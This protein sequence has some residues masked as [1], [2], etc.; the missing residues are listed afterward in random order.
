MAL[1]IDAS[2]PAV[3]TSATITVTTA[4]FT[5][6]AGAKLLIGWSGNSDSLN[7]PG[8]PTITDNLG[9]H[10]TYTLADFASRLDSPFVAGMA[11][12][13]TSEV[14]SS[15]AMTVSVTNPEN[16]NGAGN[17][18]KV[19]VITG[20]DSTTPYGAHGKAGST[21][22]TSIAQ[23]YTAQ[24]TGG[25]GFIVVNDWDAT[26]A[27]TAGTGMTSDGSA[28]NNG[29]TYGF[30]HRTSADDTNGVTNTLNVTRSVSS[31]SIHWC[32]VEILPAGAGASAPDAGA[33]QFMSQPGPSN[34][35][36][37]PWPGMWQLTY[38]W[39][40]IS[41][42]ATSPSI[43]QVA[44]GSVARTLAVAKAATVSR[45]SENSTAGTVSGSRSFPL[46]RVST[47][48]AARS[49]FG[50]TKAITLNHVTV[51][52][53]AR[54]VTSAKVYAALG[55]VTVAESARAVVARK[56]V[57]IGRVSEASTAR[58]ASRQ[59]SVP[60]ARVTVTEAARTASVAKQ[61]LL[62]RVSDAA[63]AR[64]LTVQGTTTYPISR[65]TS[66]ETARTV[67]VAKTRSVARVTDTAVARTVIALKAKAV[68]RV[69]VVE[70]AGTATVREAVTINRAAEANTARALT[71]VK[72]T[73]ISRVST[74]ETA[75]TATARK[76]LALS[77]VTETNAAR[78]VTVTIGTAGPA[79]VWGVDM[80]LM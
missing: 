68:L 33:W 73:T 30:F 46:G 3:A 55:R 36:P 28:I 24:A 37:F 49:G 47:A 70:V 15:A 1:A 60:L 34:D 40:P 58:T 69:T 25:Q 18:L 63:T 21:S 17:Q 79:E 43:G 12:M 11:A 80:G 27:M 72:A 10:L 54:T 61:V 7:P 67:S 16:P 76:M 31:T 8:N 53:S 66:T 4:S 57:A 50:F 35:G 29:V 64:P 44:E 39:D 22:Q 19:W 9:A 45:V 77:R 59:K 13:W 52:D 20:A 78:T 26:A 41:T 75:R 5:P 62:G 74:Q 38:A 42:S 56:S 51:V 65:A 71:R 2:T 14:G 6:P 32:Y 48:E 23:N